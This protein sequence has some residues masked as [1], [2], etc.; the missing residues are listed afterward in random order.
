MASR[1]AR[2]L[3]PRRSPWALE[4]LARGLS[5]PGSQGRLT[6][7]VRGLHV[8]AAGLGGGSAA[9]PRSDPPVT[10]ACGTPVRPVAAAGRTERQCPRP[11][12]S[13]CGRC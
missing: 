2:L 13:A 10:G 8:D 4:A 12:E 7:A 3:R 9:T 5:P 1:S 6:R 11:L